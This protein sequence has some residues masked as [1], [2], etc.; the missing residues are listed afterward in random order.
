MGRIFVLSIVGF[1]FLTFSEPPWMSAVSTSVREKRVQDI[2]Q[3]GN[4]S[5]LIKD[6]TVVFL[7]LSKADYD[8]LVKKHPEDEDGLAEVLSDFYYYAEQVADLLKAH[9]ISLN[10]NTGKNLFSFN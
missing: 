6:N 10:S 7:S 3:E 8:A 9:R 5:P 1:T 4:T 2:R